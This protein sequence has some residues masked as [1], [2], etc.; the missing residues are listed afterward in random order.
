MLSAVFSQLPRLLVA[1]AI[2]LAGTAIGMVILGNVFHL[3][4]GGFLEGAAVSYGA[5]LLTACAAGVLYAC[6]NPK[7]TTGAAW[8]AMTSQIVW[9]LL[10]CLAPATPGILFSLASPEWLACNYVWG[11]YLFALLPIFLG[12]PTGALVLEWR[13][14]SWKPYEPAASAP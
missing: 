12:V 2:G 11:P 13:A 8:A 5:A 3:F 9:L 7:V 1:L 10:F 14:S 4:L 6:A